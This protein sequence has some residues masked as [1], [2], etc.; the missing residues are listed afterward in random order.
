MIK[1]VVDDTI[2]PL[3]CHPVCG[4]YGDWIT[5]ANAPLRLF[6]LAWEKEVL[7]KVFF[8]PLSLVVDVFCGSTTSTNSFDLFFNFIDL[9]TNSSYFGSNIVMFVSANPVLFFEFVLSSFLAMQESHRRVFRNFH[10]R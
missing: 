1:D 8:F 10:G 6:P 3:G 9:T 4:W 7:R 5:A 2:L